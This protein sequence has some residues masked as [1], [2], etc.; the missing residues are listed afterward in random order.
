MAVFDKPLAYLTNKAEGGSGAA[1][2]SA[3]FVRVRVE[4]QGFPASVKALEP[5]N[6]TLG[7][8][9][10]CDLIIPESPADEIALLHVRSGGEPHELVSMSRGISL[11]GQP[12]A[13]QQ[14]VSLMAETVLQVGPARITLTPRVN[15]FQRAGEMLRHVKRPAS[16]TTPMAMLIV[17]AVLGI[18][19][20]YSSG[21]SPP[22]VSSFNYSLP[23]R[24]ASSLTPSA[25]LTSAADTAEE[26]NRLFQ[27]ADLGDQIKAETDGMQ[28][29]VKGSV[30]MSGEQRM[31]EITRL[32]S[33]RSRINIRSEVRP[34]SSTLV[35]AI[36]GVSLSPSRYIVLS[37][38][39]R[40]RVGDLM[41]NGWSVEQIDDKQV[42]V[43]RDGLRETLDLGQ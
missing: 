36:A 43:T 3:G 35:D 2:D 22:P 26:L 10:E 31:S 33:Q 7:S 9:P 23:E 8:S 38:G 41:P 11:N 12:F 27:A 34:D 5:G 14:R 28:V 18:T 21:N 20:W 6:Y 29:T 25:N 19:A 16:L 4:V 30:S 1:P 40:Y 15:N 24:S 13:P 32:V 39:E 37:D 42:I 17:A